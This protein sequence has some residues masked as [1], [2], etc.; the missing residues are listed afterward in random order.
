M[1]QKATFLQGW[2]QVV[3]GDLTLVAAD[4]VVNAA[5]SSLLGGGGVDG[6]IHRAGGPAI[7]EDCKQLR[8]SKFPDGLP[9]G[10]AVATSA[11]KLPAR[12]VIHTVG[13]VFGLCA[14]KEPELLRSCYWN[15][16]ALARELGATSIAFPAISTGAYHYP[17]DLAAKVVSETLTAIQPSVPGIKQVF[18]VFHTEDAAMD[19]L[20]NEGFRP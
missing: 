13:P 1:K 17:M 3:V 10:M 6:A 8:Q 19:F 5:N 12:W 14:G 7:L 2:I 20:D 9:T 15:S 4:V 18:L 16:L 11:G